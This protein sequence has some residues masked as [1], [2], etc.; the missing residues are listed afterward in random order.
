MKEINKKKSISEICE[1]IKHIPEFTHKTTAKEIS[2][3]IKGKDHD[4]IIVHEKS[5]PAGFL[6]AY[7]LD[8]KI[9]YNWL[10]GVIPEFRRK[11]YGR[12]LIEK[13]ESIARE[14]EY[15]AVQVKTMDKFKAMQRLLAEMDYNEIGKDK[16]GKII[17]KKNL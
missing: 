13:F 14:K 17:L 9:Y 6:I 8:E 10:M 16:E 7:N 11:G 3:R 1:C 2:E 15:S 4:F 5:E 12:K